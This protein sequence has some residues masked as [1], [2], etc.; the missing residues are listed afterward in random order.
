MCK[1]GRCLP[2]PKQKVGFFKVNVIERGPYLIAWYRFL[3]TWKS[4]LSGYILWMFN[5]YG[6]FELVVF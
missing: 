5:I 4:C 1:T 3:S 6:N 2:F